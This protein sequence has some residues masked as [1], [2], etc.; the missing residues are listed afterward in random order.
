[1]DQRPQSGFDRNT[2][3][4][5]ALI[6]LI[7]AAWMMFF[8]PEQPDP[9]LDTP[10]PVAEQPLPEVGSEE[11]EA[12]QELRADEVQTPSGDLFASAT[13][14]EA[15]RIAVKTD[16][17]VATLSTR[18]GTLVSMA[19]QNYLRSGSTD[20]VELVDN[21]DG[22]LALV[23]T[24]PRGSIVDTRALYF[25]PSFDGDTLFVGEGEEATLAF[26]APIAGGALTQTYTFRAGTYE[27][28]LD[29]QGEG[30][31]ILANSGG[32]DLLWDGAIPL[33]ET[34]EGINDEVTNSGVYVH[35]GGETESL[36]LTEAGEES[37]SFPGSVEWVA[38]KSKYFV[39]AVLPQA[40]TDGAEVEAARLG[41]P[42]VDGFGQAFSARL[43]MP[44][45][46]GVD[47][48]RLY[49]GPVDLNR[50]REVDGDL[51]DIVDF[52]FGETMTRPISKY[53]IAPSFR[54]LGSFLP[55]YGLVIIL[56]AFLFKLLVYPLTKKALTSQV[57]MKELQPKMEA[58]K[59]KYGDDPQKQ[60]QAMMAMY[61]EAGVNPL[62]GCL[63][64][65]LQY[66]VIISLWR[67]FQNSIVIRQEPFLWANDLS[68]PDPILHL[69]FTI[70]FYGDFVAGFCLIMGVAMAVQMRFAMPA[71]G[72]NAGQARLFQVIL[73]L[74]LFVFFNRLASGLSL[75]Y[76]MYNILTVAQQKWIE[77][78]LKKNPPKPKV[79]VKG[80]P[81]K[82]KARRSG[83]NG[84]A[85]RKKTRRAK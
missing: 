77:H 73:P 16:R 26:S 27:V 12:P 13:Q 42:G 49:L 84:V 34:A 68:A 22:A 43:E 21:A 57:R 51:F 48:Y 2:V 82:G 24:P 74:M 37:E 11:A 30:T 39:A 66:P 76:L 6:F 69:P 28:D 79:E 81:V 18:G 36:K 46:S 20:K 64:M 62:G 58:I 47:R 71:S 60:Q 5:I 19:L 14:G 56:F 67:Y 1:V 61:R 63:P 55:N 29:V 80:S 75:Y 44:A 35:S 23:F 85:T 17:Y 9:A 70:P 32:Y 25:E 59:E 54:F 65:L 52:G 33:T 38:V 8:A 40:G 41:E 7:T 50:M 45:P 83:Q 72:A 53:L 78:D 31:N 4:G 3:T 15:R 10:D